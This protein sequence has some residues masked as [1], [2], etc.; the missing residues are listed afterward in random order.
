[1]SNCHWSVYLSVHEGNAGEVEV[2]S[3]VDTSGGGE[4]NVHTGSRNCVEKKE[5]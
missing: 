3:G 4:Y 5:E 1:M 2:S